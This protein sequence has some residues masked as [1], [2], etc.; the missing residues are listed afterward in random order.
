MAVYLGLNYYLNG[1]GNK[2][3]FGVE[4]SELDGTA[5][6]TLEATTFYAAWRTLF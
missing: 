6:G 4:Y 2:F 1:N 5:A 3:M